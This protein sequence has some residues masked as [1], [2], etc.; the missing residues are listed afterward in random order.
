MTAKP[1]PVFF[2]ELQLD[3][4]P[5]YEW[6]F[7][8]KIAHP[9]TT[10][11]AESILA[12]LQAVPAEFEIREP[13]EIPLSSLRSLHDFNLMTL[14]NTA[15]QLPEDET[16]YPSVFPKNHQAKADPTNLRHAGMFCF[17][18]GTPLSAQTWSAAT[19]SAACAKQAA[20][21]LRKG[22]APILYALSRP[23]GHHAQKD[24]FGGYCYFNNAGIAAKHLRRSGRVA[25]LDVDYHHGNGTQSLFYKDDKVLVL[26][27]H[28]DPRTEYP[29]FCGYASET[30][31][32][33]GEG[34]N[35]NFPLPPGTDGKRYVRRLRKD[36]LPAIHHYA[37]DFL[38]LAA[39]HDTY[40]KDPVGNFQLKTEDYEVMG[41][42]IGRLHLPTAV[43]QEGG[44]YT[45]HL[46]RNVRSMLAGLRKGAAN[47]RKLFR[48]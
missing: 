14:Y 5:L 15:R 33:R 38:V 24:L 47:R 48:S 10:A 12:A 20:V 36:V 45:P 29:F 7:G 4:K 19:W 31:A 16:F 30:G 42:L 27:V 32:G 37:P 2:N 25:I 26:S 3:F 17:D 34:Y 6:A 35:L 1:V 39:G 46:G 13:G 8:N 11:R 28:G 43:I 22:K 21:E 41:E 23:P 40:L 18:S 9:E 44:Y